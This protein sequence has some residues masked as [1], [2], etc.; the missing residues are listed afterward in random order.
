M[1][2][3]GIM[4]KE[5]KEGEVRLLLSVIVLAFGLLSTAFL[6]FGVA[7]NNSLLIGTG[8][9]IMATIPLIIAIIGRYV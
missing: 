2:K 3:E 8:E 7:L 6:T 5:R 1:R 4:L 9:I